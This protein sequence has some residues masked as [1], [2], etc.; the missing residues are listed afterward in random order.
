MSMDLIISDTGHVMIAS[1]AEFAGEVTRV[2]FLTSKK[3]L[4][5]NYE[6]D[7]PDSELLNLEVH[8]RLMSALLK[9]PSVLLVHVRH[10]QPVTGFEVPLVQCDFTPE[11]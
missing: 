1:N 10:N 9:A 7:N 6:G 8:D 3:L 4:M 2:D 5:L 11:A